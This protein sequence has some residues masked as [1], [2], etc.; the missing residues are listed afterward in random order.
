MLLERRPQRRRVERGVERLGA[1]VRPVL[2]GQPPASAARPPPAACARPRSSPARPVLEPHRQHRRLRM[3]R[4]PPSAA[5]P[6]SGAPSASGPDASVEQ[7]PLGPPPD[8]REAPAGQRRERRVDRLHGREVGDRHLR[9]R[10]RR[11]AARAGRGRRLPVRAVPA[12][13]YGTPDVRD[14]MRG[15]LEESRH[16]VHVAVVR[17]GEAGRRRPATPPPDHPAVGRQSRCRPCPLDVRRVERAGLDNGSWPSAALARGAP[18]TCRAVSP[19]LRGLPASTRSCCAT[20]RH[21]ESGWPQLLRQ[22]PRFLALS[23][24]TAAGRWRGTATAAHPS[25]QAA[26]EEV[27][28]AA[29][30]DRR[31]VPICVDGCGVV[32]FELPLSE[33]A[34]VYARLPPSSPARWR[35]CAPTRSWCAATASST[36]S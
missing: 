6:T 25:Q 12:S 26:L 20:R 23:S 14:V 3:L 28:R 19:R 29:G 17:R 16:Q 5:R 36:P 9:D 10:A 24:A 35:R 31:Q 1:D 22:P 27:A 32:A 13:L 34:G 33:L 8:V 2:R 18:S 11:S 30:R 4:R 21:V 15:E 7:Q